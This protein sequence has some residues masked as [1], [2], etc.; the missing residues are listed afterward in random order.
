MIFTGTKATVDQ[1]KKYIDEEIRRLQEAKN[2]LDYLVRDTI[3]WKVDSVPKANAKAKATPRGGKRKYVK[4][5][6][7]WTS[8]GKKK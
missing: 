8:R 6:K 5:S 1:A 2:A 4:K 3:D 7:F